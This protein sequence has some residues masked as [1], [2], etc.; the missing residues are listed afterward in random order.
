M[1]FSAVWDLCGVIKRYGMA[2]LCLI[3]RDVDGKE[4]HMLTL[5]HAVLHV[6]GSGK[7]FRMKA[8]KMV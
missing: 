1:G 4:Q 7:H 3:S 2:L 6:C 8:W 5:C